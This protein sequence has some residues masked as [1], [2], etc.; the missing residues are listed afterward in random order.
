MEAEGTRPQDLRKS[1][2]RRVLQLLSE[3]PSQT[4]NEIV[5]KMHLSRTAVQNIILKLADAGMV[6]EG[7]KRDS[8]RNGGKRATSYAICPT[9]RYS[10]FIYL[11]SDNVLVELNDFALNRLDNR[12]ADV[13][14]FSYMEMLKQVSDL[15]RMILDDSGI[16][17]SQLYGVAIAVSG[18]VDSENGILL[19]L[20]G[21]DTNR[22]W[23]N[24][25]PLAEDLCKVLGWKLDIYIDNM[26]SFSGYAS[27]LS[28]AA[29]GMGSCVYIMAHSNGV[30]AT[31]IENGQIKKGGH[32]LLG[33]VGHMYIGNDNKYVCRCGRQGCF[34]AMLYPENIQERVNRAVSDGVAGGLLKD[35]ITSV[36]DLLRA[37]QRGNSYAA[38]QAGLI[39]RYFFRLLYNI[40]LISDPDYIIF[41]DAFPVQVDA[42]HQG[43]IESCAEEKGRFLK[44]PIQVLFENALFTEQVRKGAA[45]YL[46]SR[47]LDRNMEEHSEGKVRNSEKWG[48]ER[49]ADYRSDN[50]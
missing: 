46:R 22:K 39:G 9:Y 7:G 24:H 30:G 37:A 45:F 43:I 29:Q 1:N 19:E 48:K 20:T 6:T 17:F 21:S 4:V 11:N 47:F 34:E 16:A 28:G 8:T 12:I 27:Y 49:K 41:H 32:G 3:A 10:L 40:Q 36:D 44:V 50:G 13:S 2:N 18:M 35:E 38:E 15:I 33:E 31:Y 25:L 5:E 14:R 26:C 42:L 23:G